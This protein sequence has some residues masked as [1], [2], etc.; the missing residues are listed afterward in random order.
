MRDLDIRLQLRAEMRRLHP[1][2]SNTLVVEEL[3]LCQGIA[4]V[5]LAVVNG[6][7]HG[8]EIKSERDTLARLAGQ[9]ETYSRALEFVTIV[10]AAI[11]TEEIANVVP[12]WW[13]IW[14]VVE[15]RHGLRF[16]NV[17]AALPNTKLEAFAI[18]QLLWRHEALE[19]LEQRGLADGMRSKSRT[20]LWHSLASNLTTI[21]LADMVKDQLKRRGSSWR[22]P[23]SVGSHG[24]S[25]QPFSM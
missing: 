14:K 20:L 6:S 22:S 5:D 8:Y 9:V 25:F 11:H 13:G 16:K 21:D 1:L 3:G 10:A 2:G 4:R 23:E 18:A 7:L 17:R 19:I 12:E 24:D 15:G